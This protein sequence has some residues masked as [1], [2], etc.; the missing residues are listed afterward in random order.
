MCIR[1]RPV[2]RVK[3]DG[4]ILKYFRLPFK[5]KLKILLCI[6]TGRGIKN[7]ALLIVD[8]NIGEEGI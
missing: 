4:K 1:D 8:D 2:R 5:Q 3:K 7:F 6:G